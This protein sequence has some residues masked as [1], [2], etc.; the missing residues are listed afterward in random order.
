M[1]EFA[2]YLNYYQNLYEHYVSKPYSK[3][4]LYSIVTLVLVQLLWY[5]D[6]AS[7]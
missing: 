2:I 6:T 7:G 3:A 1:G 4:Y 5:L